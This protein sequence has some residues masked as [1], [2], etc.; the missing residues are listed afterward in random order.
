[1]FHLIHSKEIRDT[2]Q[3]LS[4]MAQLDLLVACL[5]MAGEKKYLM[6]IKECKNDELVLL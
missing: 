2:Q 6:I 1:M 4:E 5:E 3:L